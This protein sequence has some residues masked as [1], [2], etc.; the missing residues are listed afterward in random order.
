MPE[1][2]H[3]LR[4]R[5]L[6]P[7]PGLDAQL[8]MTSKN[9]GTIRRGYKVPEKHKKAAVMTLLYK[10]EDIWHTALM[11]RPESPYPHSKQVSFP[12]GGVEEIDF[13]FKHAALRETEEEF[14]IPQ[15]E[16]E[17]IGNLSQLYI[18]VSGYLVYPFVGVMN[19]V[20]SFVPD[21]SEVAEIIEV[22]VRHLLD[23]SL[24]K[25]TSIEIF[26]G[27]VLDNVPYF[28]LA[29]KVVWGATA[30]MLSEFSTVL[31]EIEYQL[32]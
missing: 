27:H 17:V 9:I 31:E 24:R 13:S 11:Q 28:D 5:L 23:Q 14:G 2:I 30:M 22:P 29:S 25:K 19:N 6:A 8:R 7:L 10:K 16:I 20:P 15:Q 32:L 18:P 3:Q 1:L 4:E 26:G 12:G 21:T